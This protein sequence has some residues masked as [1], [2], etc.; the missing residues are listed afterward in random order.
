MSRGLY[1]T[2]TGTDTGKTYVTALLVKRLRQSG[3]NAGYYKP[4]LSGAIAVD[5]QL[6]PGDCQFVADTAGLPDPPQSLVSYIYQAAVSP[7][8]AAQRENRPIEPQVILADFASIKQ[9]FDYITVEGCGGIVCPFRL[10]EQTLL[11]TDIIKLLNLDVLLVASAGLGTINQTV[12]TA[13]YARQHGI[14]IRG[15][16][17][18]QYDENS[19]L[20]QDNKQV[21]ERLTQLPV[22]ACIGE[23]AAELAMDAQVLCSY[24][25][26]V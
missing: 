5:G 3:L 9:R 6:I 20:H 22:I 8:L 11:Q 23:N 26:E 14:V 7:H 16:I 25:Q 13:E 19:F 15:I 2:A 1:I 12:L 4:A 21:I 10:D 24:Y 17:I 18:N